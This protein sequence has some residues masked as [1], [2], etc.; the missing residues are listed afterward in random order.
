[1]L[2]QT[3]Y[4]GAME[5]ELRRWLDE[6]TITGDNIGDIRRRCFMP[7]PSKWNAFVRYETAEREKSPNAKLRDAGESC[8]EQH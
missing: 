5:T 3:I 4:G 7:W 2:V 6:L 8:V 1:M